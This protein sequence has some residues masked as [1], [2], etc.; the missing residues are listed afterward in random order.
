MQDKLVCLIKHI[1]SPITVFWL[2]SYVELRLMGLK[3]IHKIQPPGGELGFLGLTNQKMS[4]FPFE[5]HRE[6]LAKVLG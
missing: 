5:C 2:V 4:L 1:F 3:L 6:I